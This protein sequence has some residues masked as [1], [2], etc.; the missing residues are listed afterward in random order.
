M[1]DSCGRQCFLQGEGGGGLKNPFSMDKLM[2]SVKKA[3]GMVQVET[4]S[5]ISEE[6]LVAER[7]I[8]N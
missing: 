3:Q 7:M 8:E 6:A 1:T 4:R 2:E 5:F